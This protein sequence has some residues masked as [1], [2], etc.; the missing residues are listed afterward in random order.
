MKIGDKV[1]CQSNVVV[2]IYD[3]NSYLVTYAQLEEG[4][5][6]EISEFIDQDEITV[7]FHGVHVL[8]ETEDFAESIFVLK[9]DMSPLTV[10]S[11]GPIIIKH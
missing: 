8:V 7:N 3:P 11:S 1:V 9:R 10:V 4:M 6:G 5:E 2:D